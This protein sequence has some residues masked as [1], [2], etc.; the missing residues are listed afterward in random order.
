MDPQVHSFLTALAWCGAIF[1]GFGFGTSFWLQAQYI[2][3][4]REYLDKVKKVERTF[5]WLRWLGLMVVS[6]SWIVSQ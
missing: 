4:Q 6:I 1:G 3:S 2:D 5:H